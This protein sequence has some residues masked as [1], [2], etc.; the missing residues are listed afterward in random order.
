MVVMVLFFHH[1]VKQSAPAG[2][3]LV[4]LST[5]PAQLRGVTGR[6]PHLVDMFGQDPVWQVL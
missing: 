1:E 5:K 6:F 2:R 4:S 3:H